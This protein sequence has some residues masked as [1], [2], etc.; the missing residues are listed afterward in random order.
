MVMPTWKCWQQN[1]VIEEP[2]TIKI[3]VHKSH[4]GSLH[5]GIEQLII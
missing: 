1:K 3:A 4:I 5:K 2:A